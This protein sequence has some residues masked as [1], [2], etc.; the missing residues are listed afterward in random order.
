MNRRTIENGQNGQNSQNSQSNTTGSK[1]TQHNLDVQRAEGEGMGT[2]HPVGALGLRQR[3]QQR[4]TMLWIK[5]AKLAEERP[6]ALLGAATSLAFVAGLLVGRRR[7][8]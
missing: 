6:A 7:S 4:L 1:P 3:L 2:M 5:A 8:A